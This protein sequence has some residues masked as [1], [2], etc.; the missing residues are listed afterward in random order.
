[1]SYIVS[2]KRTIPVSEALAAIAADRSLQ[3][4]RQDGSTFSAAW[5]EGE[6]EALFDFAQGELQATSPSEAAL[7][8]LQSLADVLDATVVGEEDLVPTRSHS[9]RPGI[10]SG[11]STWIGWPA[12]VLILGALLVWRW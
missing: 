2:V 3:V 10:L 12:M 9:L 11:R 4:L 8:K 6:D 7:L 5:S 1:M